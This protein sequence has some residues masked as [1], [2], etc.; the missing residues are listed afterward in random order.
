MQVTNDAVS[1]FVYYQ[2]QI[3][4]TINMKRDAKDSEA[5]QASIYASS[6][7]QILGQGPANICGQ[8]A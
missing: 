1:D 8:A 7:H 2:T 5:K 6:L 3:P 4:Y